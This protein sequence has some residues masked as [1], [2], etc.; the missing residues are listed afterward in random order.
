MK[1]ENDPEFQRRNSARCMEKAASQPQLCYDDDRNPERRSDKSEEVKTV[2]PL[3]NDVLISEKYE[4][5][6]EDRSQEFNRNGSQRNE[7]EVKFRPETSFGTR[8][9]DIRGSKKEAE[10]REG[11]EL[12][13]ESGVQ[14]KIVEFQK[15]EGKDGEDRIGK[16]G[17]VNET[18][19][20]IEESTR[21]LEMN[22]QGKDIAAK[23]ARKDEL[24]HGMARLKIQGQG[25]GSDYDKAGQSSSNVDSGRGSAVY[26]SGRRPPPEDQNH[27]QG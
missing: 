25:S 13:R 5:T 10:V 18:T 27:P 16:T 2:K 19:N 6:V 17:Q 24:D 15:R 23:E 7:E 4:I 8:R 20:R 26:S 11:E 22:Y 3:N 21:R 1:P 14:K 12:S 9:D